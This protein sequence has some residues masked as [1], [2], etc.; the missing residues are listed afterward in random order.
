MPRSASF[1]GIGL[2]GVTVSGVAMG[3][4]DLQLDHVVL[5]EDVERVDGDVG[6]QRQRPPGPQVEARAVARTLHGALLLVELALGQRAVVVRAPV[7]DGQQL[8]CAVE[9]ADLEILPLDDPAL[10]GRQLRDR[11]DVDELRGHPMVGKSDQGGLNCPP[12]GGR[13]RDRSASEAGVAGSHSAAAPRP[14][15]LS[16]LRLSSAHFM[17]VAEIS[18]P[19]RSRMKSRSRRSRSSTVMP[20]TSSEAIEAAAWL[21]A[22][23]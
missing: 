17:R 4:L 15:L 14:A 5:D 16:T 8:A 7:L 10:A 23:P 19:S 6:G 12:L 20:F 13:H 1:S 22:Q 11:A 21:I 18:M 3:L 9:D 2:S